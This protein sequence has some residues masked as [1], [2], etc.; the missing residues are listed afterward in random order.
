MC[1]ALLGGSSCLDAGDTCLGTNIFTN[2][3]SATCACSGGQVC[4]SSFVAADGGIIAYPEAGASG[5]DAA[6]AAAQ[7]AAVAGVAVQCLSECPANSLSSQV[8]VLDADGAS[9]S[10]CPEGTT[11]QQYGLPALTSSLVP[12]TL[13]LPVYE[14]GAY[15][16]P[17][18]DGGSGT[19]SSD[20]TTGAHDAAATTGADASA[21]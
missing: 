2:E 5:S 11:C 10:S 16:Y 17:V 3:C 6:A 18:P 1:I 14:G 7:T 13:C 12:S 15:P 20:A 8:C 9:A 21:E 4:C 19:G